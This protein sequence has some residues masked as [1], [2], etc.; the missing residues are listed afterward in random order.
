MILDAGDFLNEVYHP[1]KDLVE[2]ETK[3]VDILAVITT[4]LINYLNI[5]NQKYK[6]SQIENIKS[7]LKMDFL[8]NDIRLIAAQDMMGNDHI[9]SIWADPELGRIFLDQM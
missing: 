7:F 3:R 5:S 8:P 6:E 1:I 9:K 4:R 2:Q